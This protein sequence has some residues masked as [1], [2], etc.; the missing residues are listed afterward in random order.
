MFKKRRE[1]RRVYENSMKNLKG[2]RNVKCNDIFR[3][4][5]RGKGG[6]LSQEK[7][8]IRLP[9]MLSEITRDKKQAFLDPF[10]SFIPY[11]IVCSLLSIPV[12]DRI[13]FSSTRCTCLMVI[14]T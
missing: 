7:K 9:P 10:L 4:D 1:N 2:G 5:P 8:D 12:E 14:Q 3:R 13:S 11:L 6:L